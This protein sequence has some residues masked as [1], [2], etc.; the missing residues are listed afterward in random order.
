MVEPNLDN[1]DES[2][3]VLFEGM[4]G[5]EEASEGI[6]LPVLADIP[7]ILE[8]MDGEVVQDL[9]VLFEG[10]DVDFPVQ[11][12]RED[13]CLLHRSKLFVVLPQSVIVEGSEIVDVV[14]DLHS[15]GHCIILHDTSAHTEKVD[16]EG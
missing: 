12:T 11:N 6:V 5:V 4:G 10:L 13:L 9:A 16:I 1:G 2:N 8:V 15:C 7:T 14:V 3:D